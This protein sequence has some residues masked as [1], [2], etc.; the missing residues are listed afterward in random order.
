M[1]NRLELRLLSLATLPFRFARFAF[2]IRSVKI[3][4]FQQLGEVF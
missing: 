1:R 2:S 4:L 3:S